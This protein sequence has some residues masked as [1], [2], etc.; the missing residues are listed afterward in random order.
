MK[1]QKENNWKVTNEEVELAL[2]S[3]KGIGKERELTIL[4]IYLT[5]KGKE[6]ARKEMIELKEKLL[7]LWKQ[8]C[9]RM[10]LMSGDLA[11]YELKQMLEEVFQ[12]KQ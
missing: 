12:E 6:E 8:K 9:K 3:L 7:E 2:Q 1:L 10:E 11:F 5:E 4:T